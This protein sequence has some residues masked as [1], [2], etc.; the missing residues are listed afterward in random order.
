MRHAKNNNSIYFIVNTHY[1][2]IENIRTIQGEYLIKNHTELSNSNFFYN[3]IIIL[4]SSVCS[5][6]K[7]NPRAFFNIYIY[8]SVGFAI[9]KK[10]SLLF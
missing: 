10:Y 3:I 7:K 4:T 2:I 6:N 1:E 8:I 9:K 5:W